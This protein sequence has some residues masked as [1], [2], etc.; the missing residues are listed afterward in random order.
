MK[1][2]NNRII[3]KLLDL[4]ASNFCNKEEHYELRYDGYQDL[5]DQE[6]NDYVF[7]LLASGKPAM[8]SKFGSVE[9]S[10]LVSRHI[11]ETTG[12]T[13]EVIH[14]YLHFKN[15]Q[16]AYWA[17]LKN[18][19]SNAG[20]F[21]YDLDLGLKWYHLMMEDIKQVDI[22]GS[23]IYEEKYIA[24]FMNCSKRINIDGYFS[25]FRWKNPWTKILKDKKVLIVHPFVES[26]KYQY[27]HNREKLF[28]NPDVLPKFQELIL[29]KAV[30]T[31][32]NAKDPRF[33]TW[34]EALQYMKDE[35]DKYDYDIALIGCGAYGM[36]LAA[37][38]KRKGKQAVH[39]ASMTQMLFGIYG[40]RWLDSE[41]ECRKY[42]NKYWIRP[43]ENE[44]PVGAEKIEGGCY[45]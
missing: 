37:H 2:R 33:K 29:V 45:W 40:K 15:V 4:Y 41:P 18:L 6:A 9:L 23:Y 14:D 36:C 27:E 12:L 42:I 19:C 32:A 44:R 17:W 7:E 10:N 30:Q 22:L 39:L 43:N 28:D 38:V 20:F 25:P 13:K 31:Q 35:I 34:F 24:N 11:D 21:P 16:I 3:N 26:I 8:V 1:I 5:K